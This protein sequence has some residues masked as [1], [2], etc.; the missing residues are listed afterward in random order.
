[1]PK[2]TNEVQDRLDANV[3]AVLQSG[4]VAPPQGEAT[5]GFASL[6]QRVGE[7]WKIAIEIERQ[8]EKQLKDFEGRD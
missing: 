1:M 8:R 7:I 3:R 6:R 2:V 5:A 4:W